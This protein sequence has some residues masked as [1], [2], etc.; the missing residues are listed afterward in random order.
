MQE[1]IFWQW[2]SFSGER[3][4]TRL[5]HYEGCVWN[6][7]YEAITD[8]ESRMYAKPAEIAEYLES[9]PKKPYI[10]CEYMHAMGNS[11]GGMKLYTDLEDRY[12]KYQGGFIWDYIDQAAERVNEFGETVLSYGG[13][14]DDR[15]SD[16]EFC[17]NGI[18]Y[19]DRTISPKAQEVKHLYAPVKLIP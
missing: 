7:E 5:V 4:N 8:M 18:V 12:Q 15:A 1:K 16:Y 6:R 19:A 2:R 13:D 17:T 10:S 3:D 9:D 14:F 11:C